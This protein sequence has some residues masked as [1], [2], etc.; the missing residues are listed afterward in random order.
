MSLSGILQTNNNDYLILQLHRTSLKA[1]KLELLHQ[2][3]AVSLGS[4]LLTPLFARDLGLDAYLLGYLDF[5][6]VNGANIDA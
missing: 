4:R 1:R 2:E 6:C 5:D 3:F